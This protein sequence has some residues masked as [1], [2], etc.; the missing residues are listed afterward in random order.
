MKRFL[1]GSSSRSSKDKQSE[2]NKK[3][4]YNLPRTTEVRPCEW[5]CDDFLRAD[6]IY[7]DFYELAENVGLTAFLHDQCD[8]Y[9]LLTNTFV[10]NFHFHSRNSPPT[11]EFY[12]HDEHKEMSLHDFCR[13]C[14]IPFKGIIE[15]PHRGDVDGFI[16]TI[17]IGETRKVS[18]ART[19]SI[20]FLV[21][22]ILHYLLFIA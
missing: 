6:E 12:L 1:R 11:V 16:D 20:H 3:P 2:G 22:V 9:L 17:T 14:L 7:D 21:L 18:D 10:Q 5:P 8:Q 15:E 4:K 13:V 19:T